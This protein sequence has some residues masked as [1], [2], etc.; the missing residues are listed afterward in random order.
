MTLQE[1]IDQ[2]RRNLD[3]YDVDIS[4]WSDEELTDWLNEAQS[5][6]SKIAKHITATKEYTGQAEYDLPN[7]LIEVYKVKIDGSFAD[8]VP[9]EYEDEE[10]YY[11]WGDKLYLSVYDESSDIKVYYYRTA[12][13][14]E[15]TSD[16]P[17]I[18]PQYESILIPYVLYRAFMKDEKA[19]LAQL[20]QQE[21]TQRVQVM[22]KKY[23]DEPNYLNWRVIR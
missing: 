6:V 3:E 19:K 14:M 10:G 22:K 16:E 8:E 11:I 17:E 18:P 1:Y 13:N 21:F 4:F 20:N 5:E 7:E 2:I 12:N 15:L 23:N 9:I